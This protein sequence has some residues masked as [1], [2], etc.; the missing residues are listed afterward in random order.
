V[1]YRVVAGDCRLDLIAS[2]RSKATRQSMQA[3]VDGWAGDS[4]LGSGTRPGGLW[5]TD[6]PVLR[7]GEGEP[8]TTGLYGIASIRVADRRYAQLTL[9]GLVRGC[10]SD[11]ADAEALLDPKRAT[12]RG[13]NHIL[14]TAKTSLRVVRVK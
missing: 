6:G 12:V 13:V 5:G 8:L 3:Q 11:S 1:S 10:E 4:P 9:R 7:G 14:K 2:V